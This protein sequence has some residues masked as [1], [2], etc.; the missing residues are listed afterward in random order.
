MN[1]I[2][3]SRRI[4]TGII[5]QNLVPGFPDQPQ[6]SEKH[7]F[8]DQSP[9]VTSVL[10][11]VRVINDILQTACINRENFPPGVNYDTNLLRFATGNENVN[12]S[13][14]WVIT[15][16]AATAVQLDASRDEVVS[17]R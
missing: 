7:H 15:K 1:T 3:Y 9:F 6:I 17:S 13:F 14:R 5:E 2:R 8:I 16:R 11:T 4:K 10:R 12:V